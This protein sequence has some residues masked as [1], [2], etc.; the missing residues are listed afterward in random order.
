[1]VFSIFALLR[2]S[3]RSIL[4]LILAS[5]LVMALAGC[6]EPAMGTTAPDTT[7]GDTTTGNT[8]IG[9]TTIPDTTTG[10]GSSDTTKPETTEPE[11]TVPET[12][13]SDTTEPVTTAPEGPGGT[14]PPSNTD[15]LLGDWRNYS[16]VDYNGYSS[17]I[18]QDLAFFEGGWGCTMLQEWSRWD[19]VTGQPMDMNTNSLDY[20]T[21]E[22]TYTLEADRLFVTFTNNNLEDYEDYTVV[23]TIKRSEDG[24]SFTWTNETLADGEKDMLFVNRNIESMMN[25]YELCE[26]F[27][28]EYSYFEPGATIPD[29]TEPETTA[30]AGPNLE[31]TDDLMADTPYKFGMVQEALDGQ[32]YYLTGR[33]EGN[34]LGMTTDVNAA[35]DIYPEAAGGGFFLYVLDGGTKHYINIVDRGGRVVVSLDSAPACSY[36]LENSTP[37]AY[38]NGEQYCFGV[39]SGSTYTT[40]GPRKTS[41]S[42]YYCKFYGQ[43]A[44]VDTSWLVGTWETV[45][46]EDYE[47][48]SALNTVTFHF[49]FNG[50]GSSSDCMWISMDQSTGQ[51]G[52][53]WEVAGMGYE[54]T[55]YTYT[56][57]GKRL[58]LACTGYDYEGYYEF[59][60]EYTVTRTEDG[61]IFLAYGNQTDGRTYMKT[62]DLTSLKDLCDGLGVDYS[63]PQG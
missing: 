28:L 36:L 30:P 50:T 47:D 54:S 6:Q 12:V 3:R 38:V 33:M 4:C 42:N 49:A 44:P 53:E 46:R 40:I 57:D 52:K 27:G 58:S 13:V 11:T 5:F 9:D 59:T 43:S 48:H 61:F 16:R 56:F 62:N 32:V 51:P 45:W 22:F 19:P 37:T 20:I 31:Q 23:Y 14:V 18:I 55:S 29:T 10:E 8:T 34:Y 17:L 21:D 15:W 63:L 60:A 39:R 2:K 26:I 35:A 25:V 1:M 24:Q 41:E 7:I